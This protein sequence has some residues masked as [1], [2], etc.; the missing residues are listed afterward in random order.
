MNELNNIINKNYTI[1]FDKITLFREGGN[2]S[3]TAF[4][5]IEKYFLRI[6]GPAFFETAIKSLEIQSFLMNNNFPVPNIISTKSGDLFVMEERADGKY[7]YVLYE[8]I[9]G[10]ESDPECDA[11]AIG[12]LLGKLHSIMKTFNHELIKRDKH[13]FIGRYIEILKKKQYQKVAE[14]EK[15]GNL[16]WDKVKDLPRGYCHGD[17]YSGNI[18]KT[19]DGTLYVLDLDTSCEGFPLYDLVLICNMTNYFDYDESGYGKSKDIFER[20]LPEYQK[21]NRLGQYEINA[22]FDLIAIYH[23]ALQA[24]IIEIHGL[25][26]VDDKFLDKQLEWLY[27]WQNQCEKSSS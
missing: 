15:H 1:N 11:E 25:D 13:F 27:T 16:L 4:S 17:M 8:F 2:T 22:F 7:L 19:P 6:I 9:D 18:H 23:F 21:Y 20:L 12:K 24:T 14:F 26:C 5:G 3:Y 10:I